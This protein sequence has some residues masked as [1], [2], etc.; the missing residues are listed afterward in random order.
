MTPRPRHVLT[1]E[2]R[3]RGAYAAAEAKRRKRAKAE[4]YAAELRAGRMVRRSEAR[5]RNWMRPEPVREAPKPQPA[6]SL[7]ATYPPELRCP[8]GVCAL[9]CEWCGGPRE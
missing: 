2:E 5:Y 1:F 6:A 3:Q 8:H 9:D 7:R 4:N